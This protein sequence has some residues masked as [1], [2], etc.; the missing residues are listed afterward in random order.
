[1]TL[2]EE[3]KLESAKMG[4]EEL[5]ANIKN[6]Y[7]VLRD[8]SLSNEDKEQVQIE[9]NIYSETLNKRLG[10]FPGSGVGIQKL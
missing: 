7:E 8:S 4:A 1:M 2:T 3:V 5:K 10:I 9:L 6:C